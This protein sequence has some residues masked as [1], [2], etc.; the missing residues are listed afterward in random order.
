MPGV[1]LYS[2]NYL[3]G[4]EVGKDGSIGFHSGLCLETQYFPDSP[5]NP[6][7]P[8]TILNP[9]EKYIEKTTYRFS[10]EI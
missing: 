5:N 9:G 3:D 7:Y 10:T 4:S 8:S 1:Q 6:D 2:G